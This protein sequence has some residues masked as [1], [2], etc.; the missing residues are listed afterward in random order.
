MSEME[1]VAIRVLRFLFSYSILK[2]SNGFSSKQTRFSVI[3][4][5]SNSKTQTTRKVSCD[6]R[7]TCLLV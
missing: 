7:L 1:V 2:M 5:V 3:L 6:S 4:I